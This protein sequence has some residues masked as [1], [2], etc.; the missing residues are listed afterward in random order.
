MALGAQPRQVSWLILRSG[1]RAAGDRPDARPARRLGRHVRAAI[2]AG[3]DPRATDPVTFGAITLLLSA[4]TLVACL[5]PARRATRLDPLEALNGWIGAGE[6]GVRARAREARPHRDL[7]CDACYPTIRSAACAGPCLLVV[8]LRSR[9]P[10]R[11]RRRATRGRGARA[12]ARREGDAAPAVP[13]RPA[14]EAPALRR[15]QDLA[16]PHRAAQRLLRALRLSRKPVGVGNRAR[17]RLPSRPLRPPGADRRR[18]RAA[19]CGTISCS[20]RDFSLP[21]L[22]GDRFE[23]GVEAT[24]RHNP[25]ED[26][27]G[28]GPAS[29][30]TDRVSFL[31]DTRRSPARAVVKPRQVAL[32]GVHAGRLSPSSRQRHRHALSRRSRNA[33][34]M[35]TRRA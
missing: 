24:R 15:A 1:L 35:P 29:L 7:Q 10:A 22:A 4:V 8:S 16:R 27:Y 12:A 13:A 20:A 23:L 3:A 11:P 6:P 32:G 9:P 14:R 30:E 19:R 34:T 21:Y 28:L 2:A 18:R 17:R 5:I 26:F 25:Q 31:L 33:S